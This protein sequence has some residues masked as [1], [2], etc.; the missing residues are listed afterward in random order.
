M[1]GTKHEILYEAGRLWSRALLDDFKKGFPND[2]TIL[3]DEKGVLTTQARSVWLIF[4]CWYDTLTSFR[5]DFM[6]KEMHESF[7]SGHV[8]EMFGALVANG[9]SSD[10]LMEMTSVL[11]EKWTGLY[12]VHLR[13]EPGFHWFVA[14]AVRQ[15]MGL[16]DSDPVITLLIGRHMAHFACALAD[17]LKAAN[18]NTLN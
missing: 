4:R 14:R 17:F 18:C 2:R 12:S 10:T 1:P 8:D 7:R 16:S 11:H 6:T 13:T 5:A 15:D 3:K 9:L